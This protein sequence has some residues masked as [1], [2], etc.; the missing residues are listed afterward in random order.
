MFPL[1]TL[2]RGTVTGRLDMQ[3]CS[4]WE[5]NYWS[6]PAANRF[7]QL[8]H[9]WVPALQY[10]PWSPRSHSWPGEGA[11]VS[12]SARAGGGEAR[13]GGPCRRRARWSVPCRRSAAEGA[14]P[15][16][17]RWLVPC[18]R[19][20]VAGMETKVRPAAESSP[21]LRHWSY[22]SPAIPAEAG[23]L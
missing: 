2:I 16:G 9:L 18:R 4:H 6:S 5:Y 22:P 11:V 14:V 21:R 8:T 23:R 13:G 7:Q 1:G 12:V 19:R 15:R 17:A 3:Q 20:A 10:T